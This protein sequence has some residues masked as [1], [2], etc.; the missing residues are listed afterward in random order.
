MF[1]G[2]RV[3]ESAPV[4][5]LDPADEGVIAPSSNPDS[6]FSDVAVLWALRCFRGFEPAE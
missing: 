5:V 6:S 4:D 2:L 1:R 3:F